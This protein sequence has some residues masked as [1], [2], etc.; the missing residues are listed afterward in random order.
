MS[1]RNT[2]VSSAAC[3]MG[4]IPAAAT[5]CTRATALMITSS[6]LA[7]RLKLVVGE[8]Q[9]GQPREVGYLVTGYGHPVILE[10]ARRPGR[11]HYVP[12]TLRAY[13]PGATEPISVA[14]PYASAGT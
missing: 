8:R 1:S 3:V 7:K 14:S 9:P 12:G 10:A 6:W 11:T 4:G 2:L 13:V 5:S